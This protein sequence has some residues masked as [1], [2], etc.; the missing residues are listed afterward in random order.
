MDY[1]HNECFHV[2]PGPTVLQGPSAHS[3]VLSLQVGF[4]KRNLKERMEATSEAANGIPGEGPG[5]VASEEE[6]M[7]P[8]SVDLL[9]KKEALDG[10]STD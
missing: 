1:W 7:D 6:A 3:A 4:F 8:S 5:Q 10:G 9:P 2:L